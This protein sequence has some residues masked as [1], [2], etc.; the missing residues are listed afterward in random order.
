MSDHPDDT[1]RD[2]QPQTTTA[3]DGAVAVADDT[4]STDDRER[5][6]RDEREQQAAQDRDA[7]PEREAA[8]MERFR[9]GRD[10]TGDL[11]PQWA[12]TPQGD[13]VLARPMEYGAVKR[14]FEA[15]ADE[16]AIKDARSQA[17]QQ[18]ANPA[19]AQQAVADQVQAERG[20][21]DLSDEEL[22]EIASHYVVDPDVVEDARGLQQGDEYDGPELTKIDAQG[23][24]TI[25]TD[26]LEMLYPLAPR[27]FLMA[28]I[29]VSGLGDV[30]EV[31]MAEEQDR[32]VQVSQ[33]G[34]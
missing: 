2:D 11:I 5:L 16:Q 32:Q 27:D 10:E 18:G 17:R 33:S 21:D 26:Y 9:P 6:S 15:D 4:Q 29:D 19:E 7:S 12:E 31:E 34:N 23:R 22:C 13:T 14:F 1:T 8:G 30:F 20:A 3:A 24:E 28:V 25:T